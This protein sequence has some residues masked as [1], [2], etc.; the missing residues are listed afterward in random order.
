LNCAEF[1]FCA[2]ILSTD[3]TARCYKHPRGQT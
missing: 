1:N 3:T 2:A